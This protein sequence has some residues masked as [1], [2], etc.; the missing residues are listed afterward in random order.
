MFYSYSILLAVPPLPFS[1]L[2]SLDVW[3]WFSRKKSFVICVIHHNAGQLSFTWWNSC[4]FEYGIEFIVATFL[5]S[6]ARSVRWQLRRFQIVEVTPTS[7]H[8]GELSTAAKCNLSQGGSAGMT[9]LRARPDESTVDNGVSPFLTTP[10]LRFQ[11]TFSATDT[12]RI[13]CLLML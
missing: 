10:I 13:S 2:P 7:S 12:D 9:I 1:L 3:F 8:K 11:C 4:V 5:T 6:S